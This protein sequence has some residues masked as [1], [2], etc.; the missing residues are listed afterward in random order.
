MLEER[1]L[2]AKLSLNIKNS[3]EYL[4]TLIYDKHTFYMLAKN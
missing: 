2:K 3:T 4:K 1:K